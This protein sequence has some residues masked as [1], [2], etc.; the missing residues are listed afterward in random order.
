MKL[1]FSVD[2]FTS[3][4]QIVYVDGSIPELHSVA[5]SYADG[6]IWRLSIDIPIET[7]SFTYSYYVKNQEGAVIREWGNPR[8]FKTSEQVSEYHLEDQWMGIPYNSPFFSSAFTKAFFAPIIKQAEEPQ[9]FV[10]P[11][12]FKVFA[13][14][15]WN[16]R[17]LAIVGNNQALGNWTVK[18][19]LLMG[20]SGCANFAG[21][22]VFLHL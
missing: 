16:G 2:Y 4:G 6:D 21:R 15:V 5:M 12:T 20:R 10:S 22:V 9:S 17:C 13:P 3:W 11:I 7:D 18:K 14:E 1:Y 8:V 19:T